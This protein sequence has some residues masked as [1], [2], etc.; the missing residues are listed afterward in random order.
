MPK[1]AKSGA[2]DAGGG[3]A[4][5]G[6]GEVTQSVCMHVSKNAPPPQHKYPMWSGFQSPPSCMGTAYTRSVEV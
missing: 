6:R 5:G 3:G 2:L 1:L 4:W